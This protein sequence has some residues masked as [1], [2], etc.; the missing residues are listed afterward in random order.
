LAALQRQNQIKKMGKGRRRRIE[1]LRYRQTDDRLSSQQDTS[2]PAKV[3]S[4]GGGGDFCYIFLS[5]SSLSPA[6]VFCL[7]LLSFLE[8]AK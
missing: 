3:Y 6:F 8:I 2:K 5:F 1:W 7:I 4:K